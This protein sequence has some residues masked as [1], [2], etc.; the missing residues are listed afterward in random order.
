MRHFI[1]GVKAVWCIVPSIK[2]KIT[3]PNGDARKGNGDALKPNVD[4]LI[5][6]SL[7]ES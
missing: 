4:E 7:N 3:K 1:D 5:V 6:V 2:P